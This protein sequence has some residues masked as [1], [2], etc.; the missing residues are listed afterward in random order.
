[1]LISSC[2]SHFLSEEAVIQKVIL[3]VSASE[4]FG[5]CGLPYGGFGTFY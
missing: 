3:K 2:P 5:D 4:C 1:M